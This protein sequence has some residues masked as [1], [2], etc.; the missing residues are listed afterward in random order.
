MT[1]PCVLSA[2]AL[3]S[4]PL[5]TFCNHVHKVSC[6]ERARACIVTQ[7]SCKNPASPHASA[8]PRLCNA[9]S[10]YSLTPTFQESARK[11]HQFKRESTKK[12]AARRNPARLARLAPQSIR[13]NLD[14]QGPTSVRCSTGEPAVAPAGTWTILDGL[15]ATMRLDRNNL[16]SPST[17]A[18]AAS[19]APCGSWREV[20]IER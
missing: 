8:A 3:A 19:A 18:E 7:L 11:A 17:T 16:R 20:V 10:A 4:L 9:P 5:P 14:L 6:H 2:L 15:Q 1:S 12:R 13:L